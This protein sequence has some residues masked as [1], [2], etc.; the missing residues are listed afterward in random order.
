ANKNEMPTP[1][2]CLKRFPATD[3]R[4]AER[5]LGDRLGLLMRSAPFASYRAS[6][7]MRRGGSGRDE[8]FKHAADNETG[9]R[10]LWTITSF[11]SPIVQFA[12]DR[13]STRLNS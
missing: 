12:R 9:L 13:K 2:T 6:D 5:I 7:R 8:H 1:T 4:Y 10:R 11:C 3:Q